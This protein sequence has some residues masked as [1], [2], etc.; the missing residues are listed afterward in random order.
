M[1]ASHGSI[2]TH[3]DPPFDP[4]SL[5]E[6]I[7]GEVLLPGHA[8]FDEARSIWNGMIDRSPALIIRPAN[9]QDVATAIAFAREHDLAIAIKSGGHNVA[10]YAVNDDGLM[11]DMSLMR[12]V[13]VDRLARTVTV[14]GGA[15]WED[16]DQATGALG[17]ATTGGAISTTGV[18]GL[19][20]GGGVGWLAGNFGM[21]IDNLLEVE[22]VTADGAVICAN[23]T[24]HAD[25]FW[26]LRGGGGNFGVVTSLRF[27]LHPL[28]Q[29]LAGMIA[30]P[31]ER[32]RDVLEFYRE[33][34]TD[35]PDELSVYCSLMAEPEHGFR[36]VG[37]AICWSG[38]LD[39]GW[40]VLSAL[41]RLGEPLVKQ[42]GPM[43]YADWQKANNPL[44]PHKRRYYWKGALVTDLDDKLLDIV[45]DAGAS[46]EL[47]WA[48]VTIESYGGALNRVASDATAFPHREARFQVLAIGAWDDASDDERG[49]TWARDL[50]ERVAPFGLQGSFLNFVTEDGDSRSNRL[51]LGYGANWSRLA[52]IKQRYDPENRFRANNNIAPGTAN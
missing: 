22:L 10:G 6:S 16:V 41:D 27:N 32:S 48:N 5:L 38:D 31:A 24:E 37:M 33:F 29:V 43:P 19:T 28:D 26:A 23:E 49:V 3:E 44:F 34:L 11:I 39:E 4:I 25:L 14:Q 30:F 42:I 17:L 35:K 12:G 36:I 7:S 9:A 45:A 18:A 8:G 52:G 13:S 2:V 46:P 15:T 21:A 40:R 51:K 1:V 47:P 20:L 50:H